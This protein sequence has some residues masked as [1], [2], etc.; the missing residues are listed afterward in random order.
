MDPSDRLANTLGV[1]HGGVAATLLDSAF[2][3][4]V[5]TLL[6]GTGQSFAT[7]DLRVSYLRRVETDG[8][9]LRAFG[10]VVHLGRRIAFTEGTLHAGDTLVATGTATLAIT[11]SR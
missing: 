7:V 11:G 4:A 1:V 6:R 5:A 10:R 2:G 3:I 8:P 9:R